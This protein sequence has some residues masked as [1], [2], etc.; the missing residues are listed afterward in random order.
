MVKKLLFWPLHFHVFL[1]KVLE[2]NGA[3]MVL[4]RFQHLKKLII[5]IGK[6]LITQLFSVTH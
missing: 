6:K 5:P 1:K 3:E 4:E 2:A